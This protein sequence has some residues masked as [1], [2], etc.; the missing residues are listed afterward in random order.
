MP[1]MPI[2]PDENKRKRSI[3]KVK[4]VKPFRNK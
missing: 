1:Q 4:R 3:I 2:Y